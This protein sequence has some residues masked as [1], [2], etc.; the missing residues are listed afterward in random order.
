MQQLPDGRPTQQPAGA[1][2]LLF[3]WTTLAIAAQP[4]PLPAK[5]PS[6]D[7]GARPG[8]KA[9]EEPLGADAMRRGGPRRPPWAGRGGGPP[10]PAW[11]QLPDAGPQAD[12]EFV[13]EHFPQLHVE[14]RKLEDLRPEV[15]RRRM[16]HIAHEMRQ[17]M[18]AL[19]DDPQRG[20]LLIRERQLAMQIR[21]TVGRY[22]SAE[23]GDQRQ[24]ARR[25]LRELSGQVFDC[26]RERRTV[27]VRDLEARLGEMKGRLAEQERMREQLI[28]RRVKDILERADAGL[29]P[30]DGPMPPG[31]DGERPLPPDNDR[32]PRPGDDRPPPP[33]GNGR[34][35]PDDQRPP[36]D[37]PDED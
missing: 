21:E 29:E 36:P 37:R 20:A 27:E 17:L 26:Q 18:I 32:P 31:E 1:W 6:G 15:F 5:G 16:T 14:L 33:G 30:E 12:R 2:I 23:D 34:F 35:E 24:R 13:E 19:K 9:S 28:D 25:R 8:T 3:A 10:G 11:D 7:A 22:R 4:K